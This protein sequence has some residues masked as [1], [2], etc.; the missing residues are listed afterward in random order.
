VPDEA[1]F[2]LDATRLIWRRWRGRNP[3]GID[4][5]CLAYLRHFADRSQAVVHHERFRRILDREASQELF[6]L[7]EEPASDFRRR[8]M[9]GTLRNLGRFNGK[10]KGRLY[11]NVGHTGLNSPGFRS[12][13]QEAD[14]R[15]IYL[16]HDLIPITHPQFCRAGEAHK[17][18]ERMRTVLTTAAGIIGNSKATL[19]DISVFAANEHL[20]VPASL[21]AWL[22]AD[23]LP[24]PDRVSPS[25][26]PTFVTVG[27]I[28]AR[29][30][31]LLLLE[32]WS[33]LVESLGNQAPRLL[34]IGQRGWEAEHVFRLLDGKGSLNG[35]VIEL[36]HST[37]QELANHLASA[38]ALLFPS[39]AEGYGLPLIEALAAGTPVI[40]SDLPVFREIG[41]DIPAY[42]SPLDAA[43]WRAAILDYAR[44]DSAA[45]AAQ[46]KRMKS[47]RK[48]DWNAHFNR[49]EGWLGRFD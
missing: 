7:L 42:F 47:F 36:N 17:H 44:L 30:N 33:T 28:E 26:P 46:L 27:T 49:V 4:R 45:R 18:R 3:T 25:Q 34:V 20:E 1:P 11:L 48:P 43:G 12:W 38:R 16:V 40:A 5:V 6:A 23:P 10:G 35:H 39:F 31:H 32:I 13:V 29:K 21:A 19:A 15:P 37:D 22:G 2:L 8:L 9:A 41:A 14:V 24:A